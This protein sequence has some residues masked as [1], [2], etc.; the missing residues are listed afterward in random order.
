M[1]ETISSYVDYLPFDLD[2]DA[3]KSRCNGCFVGILSDDVG[4]TDEV[5]EDGCSLLIL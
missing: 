1:R 2:F 3:V 5:A 4:E